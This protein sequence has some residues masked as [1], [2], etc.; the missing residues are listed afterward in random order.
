MRFNP[1]REKAAEFWNK[2]EEKIRMYE[3]VPDAGKMPEKQKRH[4]YA[5]SN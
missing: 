1:K 4:F 2:F 3:N 5:C